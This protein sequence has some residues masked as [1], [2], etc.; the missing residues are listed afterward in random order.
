MKTELRINTYSSHTVNET[1]EKVVF[2][3]I[4]K[5]RIK[6]HFKKEGKPIT[7]DLKQQTIKSN[8]FSLIKYR[9][10]YTFRC[11]RTQILRHNTIRCNPQNPFKV[12]KGD[13]LILDVMSGTNTPGF[14]V[15]TDKGLLFWKYYDI[16]KM[17]LLE[18][19]IHYN[20]V[21]N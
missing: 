21:L 18:E 6:E 13:I 2:S 3:E 7:I 10:K 15:D 14:Y 4:D 19:E 11:K 12:N 16:L 1:M 8:R 20:K 17:D 9:D 5:L